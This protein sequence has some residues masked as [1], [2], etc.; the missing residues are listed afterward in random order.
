MQLRK[1]IHFFSFITL[2]LSLLIMT[3][4]GCSNSRG[5]KKQALI[6]IVAAENFY[7]EAAAQVAGNY[8]EVVSLIT[9]PDADPHEFEPT[10]LMAGKISDAD[11]VIYNGLGYDGW[12]DKIVGAS[13]RTGHQSVI[14][15]AADIM[16]KK[17]G[18]NEHVW[19]D[20]A[21][22]PK[23]AGVLAEKLG[24]LDPA[25]A[26][27]FKSNAE[28]YMASLAPLTQQIG[29][30]RQDPPIS[31]E[32]SEPVFDYMLKALNIHNNSTLFSKAVEEGV[33]PSPAVLAQMQQDLKQKKVGIFI[34]NKQAESPIVENLARLA[35]ASG[36][37]VVEVTETEPAGQNY[38]QWMSGQLKQI[39][40][41]LADKHS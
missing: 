33:D 24:K 9:N 25:H 19:Y 23:L 30:L 26:E 2:T 6:Q 16:G 7:G 15:V 1:K 34:K 41:A 31:A 11:I 28:A 21:T 37:P 5:D 17:D 3:A 39:E 10:P 8:A 35:E 13:S 32:V 27:T 22:M 14:S 12:V 4:S 36:I 18:D 38:I 20:P 40:I 29:N